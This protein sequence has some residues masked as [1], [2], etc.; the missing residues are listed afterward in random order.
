M[1]KHR[2]LPNTK[3]YI[4]SR[5]HNSQQCGHEAKIVRNKGKKIDKLEFHLESWSEILISHPQ[6]LIKHQ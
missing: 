2:I 5:R 3:R 6:K 4:S 1:R